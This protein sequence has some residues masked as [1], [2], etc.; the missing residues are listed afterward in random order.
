MYFSIAT[1]Y[2]VHRNYYLLKIGK[3]MSLAYK[4]FWNFHECFTLPGLAWRYAAYSFFWEMGDP[5]LKYFF[6]SNQYFLR[7]LCPTK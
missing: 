2:F 7:L 3:K 6:S 1:R 4:I 5:K